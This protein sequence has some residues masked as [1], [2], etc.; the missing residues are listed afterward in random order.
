MLRHLVVTGAA[1]LLGFLAGPSGAF[2]WTPEVVGVRVGSNWGD[3]TRS[4]LQRYDVLSQYDLP[5]NWRSGKWVNMTSHLEVTAGL[6]RNDEDST[7][8]ASVSPALDVTGDSKRSYVTASFGLLLIADHKLGPEDFGG[9]LQVTFGGG[10]G[11]RLHKQLTL[12]YRYHHFSDAKLYGESNRG[13][14]THMIELR[15]RLGDE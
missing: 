7:F 4:D 2:D 11:F 9:P 5:L 6:L 3:D 1:V 12:G 14:D 10:F 15:Y 8:L 13:V